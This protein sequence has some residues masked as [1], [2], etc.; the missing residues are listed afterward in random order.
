M[1]GE[2]APPRPLF[3]V[4]LAS[5]PRGWT[6][7][8]TTAT[9]RGVMSF[10]TKIFGDP[11]EKVLAGIRPVIEDINDL[12]PKYASLSP[13]KLREASVALH[14]RLRAGETTDDILPEAFALCREA[15]KRT[16]GQR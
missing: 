10:L 15:A 6:E 2:R 7:L 4:N 11:N 13:E 5:P 16:L 8:R 12:E 3:C 1:T 14:D 9:L